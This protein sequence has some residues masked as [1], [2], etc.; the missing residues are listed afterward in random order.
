[1]YRGLPT[2]R[3]AEC[4]KCA[5][6]RISAIKEIDKGKTYHPRYIQ[7]WLCDSCG[8]GWEWKTDEKLRT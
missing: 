2:P 8:H 6:I 1:M 4:P 3:P 7:M 5:S